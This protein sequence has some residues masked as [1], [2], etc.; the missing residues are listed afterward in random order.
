MNLTDQ[1]IQRLDEGR[2]GM[3]EV[4]A[5]VDENRQIYPPWRIKEIVAHITGWDDAVIASLTADVIG[6]QSYR[7]RS[8]AAWLVLR[9]LG[10]HGVIALQ[11]AHGANSMKRTAALRARR[12][13]CGCR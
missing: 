10:N 11:G 9:Q 8:L 6:R 12:A 2:E 5:I 3:L 7:W 13:L 4:V 1:L